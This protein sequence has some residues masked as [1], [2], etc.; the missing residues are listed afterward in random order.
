M[1]R[2]LVTGGAGFIGRHLCSRLLAD[3]HSVICMDNL[4]TGSLEGMEPLTRY[5]SF[6]FIHHDVREPYDVEADG[7]FNLACPASP[8][9]YQSDPVGTAKTNVLGIIHALELARARGARV[10]QASTSEVYGEPLVHP[11]TENYRGN[12][13]PVGIRSCYDEGKRMAETFC[14]DYHRQYGVESRI[15]R[16]FNTYGPGMLSSD[17]RVVSNLIVQALRSEDLTIYGDGMQT[18][19]FC[20]VSDTVDALVRMMNAEHIMG[21]VNVGNP[22]EVTILEIA[23]RVLRITGSAS[24]IVF[25]PFPE[26]DP[27]RR[28]PDITRAVSSLGWRPQV[29]L[30]EG[31]RRTIEAF[32][33]EMEGVQG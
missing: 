10:L 18:R 32:R 24:R 2:Y 12:V 15:V 17:G 27:H 20:Y 33:E 25:Q 19:S 6:R 26:D 31:L 16:I 8:V 29:Q 4:F 1:K 14:F 5:P 9:H 7:I 23:Q 28:R 3:G 11:Q 30:D 13:N 21:P 22:H